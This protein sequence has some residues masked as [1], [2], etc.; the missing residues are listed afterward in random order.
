MKK[1]SILI[2]LLALAGCASPPP[3]DVGNIC[4]I[5]QQYPGWRNDALDA[6]R[7]WHVPVTVQMAIMHQESKFDAQAEP[8]RKKIFWFIYGPHPTTAHGY[9]QAL[10][11][12]WALYK[13]STGNIWGS[14][15]RFSDAVDFIGWYSNTA[16]QRAKISLDN[17]HDL[18][19]AYHEG[20]TGYMQK[21]YLKKHWLV[22]VA[23]KV[24]A[25]DA[26][27]QAK[28]KKCPIVPV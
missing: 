22:L 26:I 3:R 10:N 5:F 17:V 6:E 14:R 2:I 9:S 4:N 19:L 25:R 27:Y 7:R 24:R 13:K 8:A 12:T 23:H 28:L 15:E 16:H 1:H 11:G 21:T 20:V 18:Y